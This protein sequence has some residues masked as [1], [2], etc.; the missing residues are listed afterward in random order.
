MNNFKYH[1]LNGKKKRKKNMDVLRFIEAQRDV[2]LSQIPL[3]VY[4]L[5]GGQSLVSRR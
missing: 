4:I 3:Q 1:A 5:D 2:L